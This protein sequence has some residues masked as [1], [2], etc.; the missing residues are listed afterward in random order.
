MKKQLC[1]LGLA[2]FVCSTGWSEPDP[3]GKVKNV[4]AEEE[5]K[6]KNTIQKSDEYMAQFVQY[7]NRAMDLLRF[8]ENDQKKTDDEA[9]A[10]TKLILQILD[11]MTKDK[12]A[13][14]ILGQENIDKLKEFSNHLNKK[15]DDAKEAN[16]LV[17]EYKDKI[18]QIINAFNGNRKKYIEEALQKMD[19]NL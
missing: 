14:R 5:P 8:Q 12:G 7:L 11:V 1:C 17:K 10:N 9:K 15:S 16:V 4:K 13:S 18:V 2:L 3:T 6:D 19:N